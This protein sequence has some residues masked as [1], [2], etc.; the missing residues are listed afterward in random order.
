LP[1]YSFDAI[2][3]LAFVPLNPFAKAAKRKGVNGAQLFAPSATVKARSCAA[4]AGAEAV[5]VMKRERQI[6]SDRLG[7]LGVQAQLH[8]TPSHS[9]HI[10]AFRFSLFA[11]RFGPPPRFERRT[12]AA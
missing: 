8:H 6:M 11:F 1:T 4:T 7:E 2:A 5:A 10:F 9:D 3:L 12:L